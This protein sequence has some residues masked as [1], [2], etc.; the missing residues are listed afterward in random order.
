M[1][2]ITGNTRKL[3]GNKRCTAYK[4]TIYLAT[5]QEA[6]DIICLYRTA[7][8]NARVGSLLAKVIP[9]RL[10]N[11]L[12]DILSFL[13]GCNLAGANCPY[14]LVGNNKLANAF[15]TGECC[16]CLLD[17]NRALSPALKFLEGLPHA[18]NRDN[19]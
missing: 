1:L 14:R 9:Q 13:R 3:V 10:A 12:G 6:R 7:V 19:A 8:E 4:H 15:V 2:F 5:L 16:N 11:G 18:D 17:R